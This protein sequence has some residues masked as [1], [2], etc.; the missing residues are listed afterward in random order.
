MAVKTNRRKNRQNVLSRKWMQEALIKLLKTQDLYEISISD[1]TKKAG[2]SRVTFYR[3]YED[4]SDVLF[5]YL[6]LSEFG[7]NEHREAESYLPNLLRCYFEFCYK[8]N[9]VINTIMKY[10]LQ[11]RFCDLLVNQLSSSSYL[12]VSSY[13]YKSKYEISALVG[14]VSQILLEWI[15]NGMKES[16][17]E[18]CIIVYGIITKFN[19]I[20]L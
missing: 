18:M 9:V 14:I 1:L 10:N 13:G 6:E 3:N 2:I 8:N 4:I 20:E 7:M 12:L 15:R 11:A 16:V 17:E 19:C 5:D